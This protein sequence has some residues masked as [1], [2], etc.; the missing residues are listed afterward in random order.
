VKVTIPIYL[1]SRL[2]TLGSIPPMH[3]SSTVPRIVHWE[4]QNLGNITNSKLSQCGMFGEWNFP[5]AGPLRGVLLRE[6]SV[7][8]EHSDFDF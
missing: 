3:H 8:R 7:P 4:A 2:K 1:A 6:I 5:E